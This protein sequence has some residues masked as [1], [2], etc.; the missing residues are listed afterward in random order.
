MPVFP[1]KANWDCQCHGH[2]YHFFMLHS[3][4]CRQ[5]FCKYKSQHGWSKIIVYSTWNISKVNTVILVATIP[6][7]AMTQEIKN[8][9]FT[10]LLDKATLQ[11]TGCS[12]LH[13][14]AATALLIF[15]KRSEYPL[16]NSLLQVLTQTRLI[17]KMKQ[18]LYSVINGAPS[19]GASHIGFTH[20]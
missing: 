15:I 3:A 20:S 2:T 6:A 11:V 14:T 4:L 10:F 8:L 13:C 17:W 5:A 18:L 12:T 16:L 9:F 7:S 1:H 19:H